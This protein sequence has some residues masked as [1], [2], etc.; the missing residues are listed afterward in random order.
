[1][2]AV[3]LGQQQWYV[4]S[5]LAMFTNR[6]RTQEPNKAFSSRAIC[7]Q[8]SNLPCLHRAMLPQKSERHARQR[9]PEE[10]CL[11]FA[12]YSAE[13]LPAC[14][15]GSAV[16]SREE[17]AATAA[18]VECWRREKNTHVNFWVIPLVDV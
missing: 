6:N 12:A 3:S 17:A 11:G 10:L 13:K 14:A 5:S 15:A 9:S 7:R 2:L 16:Q 18:H 1:M 8:V 4:S